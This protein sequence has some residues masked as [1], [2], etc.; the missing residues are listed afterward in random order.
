MLRKYFETRLV[1]SVF[2]AK[3]VYK[4]L[5]NLLKTLRSKQ[6]GLLSILTQRHFI[7]WEPPLLPQTSTVARL[8]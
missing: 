6:P 7:T 2:N 1:S 5:E 8:Y 4:D 3:R